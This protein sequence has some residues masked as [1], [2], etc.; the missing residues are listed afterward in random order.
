MTS[1]VRAMALCAVAATVVH[2]QAPSHPQDSSALAAVPRSIESAARNLL[3]RQQATP[4]AQRL[5]AD[6]SAVSDMVADFSPKG[7]TQEGACRFCVREVE[8]AI[9]APVDPYFRGDVFLGFSDAEGVHIEQAYLTA[10]A[11]PWGLEARLGRFLMPFTKQNTTHRHDLHTIDYPY[12]LQRFLGEEGAKGTG[13]YASKVF[14]PLGFYQELIVTAVDR[15]GEAPEDLD[16]GGPINN[17]VDRLGYSARLRNY[18]DISEAANLEISGGVMTGPREQPLDSPPDG[19][20]VRQTHA[21]GDVTFRWRPL[22]QGNYRSFIAQ[23]EF[24]RQINQRVELVTYEGPDRDFNGFYAFARWQLTRRGYLGARFDNLQ[25]PELGGETL[26]AVSGY[27]QWFPSEFSKVNAAFERV[28]RYLGSGSTGL[29][30][31]LLQAAFSVGP[32]KPHP[33]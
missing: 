23:A 27:L 13:I 5:A 33:F 22:Q 7:S 2:A 28:E 6:I 12:V 29:N 10:T 24:I 14:S 25:D 11:L 32:H 16:I 21:G 26:R 3:R 31:I 30:R 15:I 4:P 18:W 20:A 1:I 8:L 9:Q 17:D 19:I